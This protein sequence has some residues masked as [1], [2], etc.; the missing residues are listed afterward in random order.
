MK[1]DRTVI[2]YHGC[3]AAVA[4]RVL[5]GEPFRP[6]ENDYDWLGSGIYF[7]EYGHH[8]AVRFAD[9]QKVHR[10]VKR[11]A[12]VGAVVQ[13]GNCFDLMD[14][15]FTSH[16]HHGYEAFRKSLTEGAPPPKNAGK[17]PDRKLRRLDCAVLNFYF[18]T[19]EEQGM[20]YDSVRCAF[21]EGKPAFP[22][23]GIHAETHI[24]IAVRNSSCIVGAFRPMMEE[25]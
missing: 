12:V 1:Y 11:P 19:L 8:R 3:D 21:I 5:A 17:T 13:L 16:L 22:G 7:W 15:K 20:H 4:G 25:T 10:K 2:A 9:F 14:T 24:Q 18:R 6:S 23:S